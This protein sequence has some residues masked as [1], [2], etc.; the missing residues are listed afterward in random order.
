MGRTLLA[1]VTVPLLISISG[2][3]LADRQEGGDGYAQDGT[4]YVPGRGEQEV[5]YLTPYVRTP[6]LRL[7]DAKEYVV[8]AEQCADHFRIKNL[9]AASTNVRWTARGTIAPFEPNQPSTAKSSNP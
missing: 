1:L 7:E 4:I 6:T 3:L 5:Y 8:L 9:S 2:C